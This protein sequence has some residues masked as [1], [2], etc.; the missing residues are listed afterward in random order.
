MTHHDL[1]SHLWEEQRIR[2][3]HL[4]PSLLAIMAYV[5]QDNH[6]V[7]P[8]YG[9]LVT[10]T[11][12]DIVRTLWIPVYRPPEGVATQR[13]RAILDDDDPL[14]RS[15]IPPLRD[16]VEVRS[17]SRVARMVADRKDTVRK[18]AEHEGR[19]GY[20]VSGIGRHETDEVLS[21]CCGGYDRR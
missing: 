19:L 7:P 4:V 16:G 14:G 15:C 12:Y 21:A 10:P 18:E 5:L 20:A 1:S 6:S 8:K 17:Q 2:Q 13:L 11:G 9:P 3:T